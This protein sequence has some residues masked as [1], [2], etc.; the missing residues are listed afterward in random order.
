MKACIDY[1]LD[2]S[3]ADLGYIMADM[4]EVI[5]G[6]KLDALPQDAVLSFRQVHRFEF[7]GKQYC[8]GCSGWIRIHTL[9]D[10]SIGPST[11]AQIKTMLEVNTVL[12]LILDVYD[13]LK[14]ESTGTHTGRLSLPA[15]AS[16]KIQIVAIDDVT[17]LLGMWCVGKDAAGGRLFVE[18]N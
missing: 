13:G 10:G 1:I 18:M 14:H 15:D 8:D 6:S 12:Y 9:F 17:V 16:C 5:Y 7:L 4:F 2:N 11:A 3:E